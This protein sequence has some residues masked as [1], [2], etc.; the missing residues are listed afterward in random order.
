M[1]CNN[2]VYFLTV[3][4]GDDL[5][6]LFTVLSSDVIRWYGRQITVTT[7]GGSHSWFKYSV[8]AFRFHS[9]ESN[10]LGLAYDARERRGRRIESLGLPG[11]SRN[12]TRPSPSCM[13]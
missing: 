7:G 13:A 6:S 9:E 12:G 2:K 4:S 10:G 1:F 11:L 8:E 3:P 5:L